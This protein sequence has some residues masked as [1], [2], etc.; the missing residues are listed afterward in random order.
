M[1]N[2]FSMLRI[3]SIPFFLY[4]M[5]RNKVLEALV[6]FC[7]A[8]ATDILD[9]M[10]ARIWNQKTKIGRLLDPAADK[11]LM[12]AAIVILSFPAV[13]HPNSIPLWLTITI[14]GRDVAIVTAAWVLYKLRGQKEFPPS[15]T[16][17]AST[18]CQMG[19]ILGTLLLNILD[20][21]PDYL[22]WLFILTF[23]LTVI[24]GFGYGMR[25]FRSPSRKNP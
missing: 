23:V 19:T 15:L 21:T 1:P 9:G 25:G 12:T 7:L 11:L 20:R 5:L 17:K 14:I 13:S 3:F 2:F 22:T 16:G 10:T 4:L 6:V 18:V 24:S 8:S